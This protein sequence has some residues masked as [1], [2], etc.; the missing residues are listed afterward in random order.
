MKYDVVK[1]YDWTEM[2]RGSQM[3]TKGPVVY[4]RSFKL[5]TNQL[6]QTA[7]NFINIGKNA[8]NGDAK[9]FY[10]KMYGDS[11]EKEDDFNFPFMSDAV[12]NFSN[13]FG[14]T[15]QNGVGGSG[16]IG[17]S[18][19]ETAKEVVGTA[20]QI[21][22]LADWKGMGKSFTGTVDALISGNTAEA[23][24]QGGE[25]LKAATKGNP[26]NYAET[27]QFYQFEKTDSPLDVS[28]IL[29]NTI[30]PDWSKNQK[31]VDKLTKI[32]RPLRKNSMTVDPPRI[33][34]VKVPGLRY[35]RWAVCSNFSVE[36]LGTRRMVNNKIVPDAYRISM[37]FQSLTLEHAGFM[38]QV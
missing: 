19:N 6:M 25:M 20:G 23:K 16:G 34:Q 12:R 1:D 17:E 29:Y 9:T 22:N 27:P 37:S 11:T 26:G 33:Y 18:V 15:F 30:N 3:R 28:F 8:F 36:L 24:K 21:I 32:N 10:D 4:V 14:E 13:T 38:D 35:I 2:A 5:N 31:L 7:R